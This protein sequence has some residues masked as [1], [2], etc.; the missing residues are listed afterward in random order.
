[1]NLIQCFQTHST[2]YNGAVRGGQPVGV[3][4]H[5]TGAKNPYLKRYVQPYK[6]DPNYDEMIALIGLNTNGND[7]NHK[8][9]EAGLNAWI[10][11]L[12]DGSVGTVQAGEWDIH[13]WGCGKGTKG[14]LN[15]YIDD[16][17]G[18]RT[19]TKPMWIQFELCDDGYKD[20]DYFAKVYKEACE[21]TAFIC[22]KFGIDPFGTYTFNGVSVPTV[23]CHKDAHTLKVASNHSDVITWFN[24]FGK[25]MEDVRNDVSALLKKDDKVDYFKTAADAKKFM[26]ALIDSSPDVAKE[27]LNTAVNFSKDYFSGK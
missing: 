20:A 14:S 1:M 17:N 7:W 4:W 27:F 24:K 16:K 25:S 18:K 3:L 5:D 21:F 2:W 6:G 22:G 15:G 8:K 10:G 9:K 23:L 11:K 26:D 13:P 12:Q 19:W